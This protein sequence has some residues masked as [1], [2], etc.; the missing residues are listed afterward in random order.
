MGEILTN[1]WTLI[2]I[3]IGVLFLIILGIGIF[4]AIM[5][6]I[7]KTAEAIIEYFRR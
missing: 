7:I 5:D 3:I 2:G 1:I 6:F 4:I